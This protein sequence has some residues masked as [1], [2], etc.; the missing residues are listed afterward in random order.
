MCL[1]PILLGTLGIQMWSHR[2]EIYGIFGVRLD[3]PSI[4]GTPTMLILMLRCRSRD[5]AGTNRA[6]TDTC[7]NYLY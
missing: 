7:P 3:R 1:L 6:V 4:R 2:L 5:P